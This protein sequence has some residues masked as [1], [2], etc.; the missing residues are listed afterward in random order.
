M[1]P[2][3]LRGVPITHVNQVWS[4]DITSIRLQGGFV[5]VVAVRDWFSRYVLSWAVSMTLDGRCCLDALEQAWWRAQPE[6][7]NRDPGV[8]FTSTDFTS[9]L[10]GAGRRI[11]MDGRGRAL[12]H[13]VIERLWRTVKYEE[14]YVKDDETPR[15]A[16]LGLEPYLAFYHGQRLHQALDYQPPAA[17]YFGSDA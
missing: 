12:D 9:R 11:S 2:D 13:V 5:S 1:Y 4:T 7:F 14:V 6:V 8:Q 3:W 17:V 16:T 10:A 15:E